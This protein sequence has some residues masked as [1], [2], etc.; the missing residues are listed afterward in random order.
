MV[1]AALAMF[2][3]VL[4]AGTSRVLS[5]AGEDTTRPFFYWMPFG[6]GELRRGHLVLWNPH[7]YAGTPFFGAFGPALLYPP[8]WLHMALPTAIAINLTVTLH[9]VLAGVFVYAWAAHRRL[10]F[11]ACVFA[12]LLFM[13][14]GAHFWQIWRGHLHCLTTL[15]WAP[16][17]FL[18]IDGVLDDGRWRWPLVGMLAVAMQVLAGH[19]QYTFYTAIVAASYALLR[20]LRSEPRVTW[21]RRWREALQLLAI[22]VGG[23]CLAAVQ[24]VTGLQTAAES[25]R[26]KISWDM[27][28]WFAFPPENLLTLVMPE[29]FGDAVGYWGRGTLTEMCLFIGVAPCVLMMAG[30]I[31]GD[32]RQRRWSLTIAVVSLILAFGSYTPLFRI[33]YDHVPGFA[34]FRGTTKFIFLPSLFLVMLAAVGLD[35]LLRDRSIAAWLGPLAFL[36]GAALLSYGGALTRDCAAGARGLWPDLLGSPLGGDAY[37]YLI[38]SEQHDQSV[39]ACTRTAVSLRVAGAT[40]VAVSLVLVASLRV[41]RL[42]YALVVIGVLEVMAYGR[43]T[44]ATFDPRPLPERSAK[45]RAA[46]DE[47]GAG[48][49]RIASSDPYSYVAMGAG[50]SDLW[51]AEPG[52][53]GRYTH[54]VAYAQDW[55]LD[56]L[57]VRPGFRQPSTLFGMLRL[58]Y[59]LHVDQQERLTLEPTRLPELPRALLLPRWRVIPDEAEVLRTLPTID[60]A[61]EALLESDPGIAPTDVPAADFGR[62]TVTD[63]ST[64]VLEVR[65]V[66]AH[67]ALLVITDNYS[68]SWRAEPWEAN[69]ARTYRV[70]PA[71]YLLRGI[72]LAAGTHHIRVVY[73]PSALPWG[74]A[75]STVAWLGWGVAAGALVTRRRRSSSR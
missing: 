41:P 71:N 14:C 50:A 56:A 39:A 45:L 59:W 46:L 70:M 54:F 22:Y 38:M 53:L 19:V 57:M 60:P 15:A 40:F 29:F 8:N 16:L 74:A 30:I 65:V 21:T 7:T 3:D 55:P 25:H 61:R 67:P 52:V 5:I 2:G 48:D 18:A 17:I 72:P 32:R 35:R 6:F 66:T 64:E 36:A 28:S 44:R 47:Q 9:L 63:V 37:Q 34:S 12:G 1:L 75:L 73:R 69:D 13:F 26:A 49:A 43:Y 4:L 42:A 51:G 23:A 31:R 58:R 10:H 33:L 62:V 24:L 20:W 27:A 68:A 11:A